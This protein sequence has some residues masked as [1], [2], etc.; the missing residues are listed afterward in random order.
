MSKNELAHISCEPGMARR[1]FLRKSALIALPVS[2]SGLAGPLMAAVAP[3]NYSLP[4]LRRGSTVVSV[5]SYGALGNGANDDTD[6]FQ[7]AINALPSSGGT[8]DV[9]AGTY[10]LDPTVS[11][12]LRSNM[13]LRLADGAQLAAK[14]NSKDRAYVLML[15]KVSNVEIS[16]GQIVGD[17]DN[18]LGTTGEWGHAIQVLGSTGV[19]IRD[20]HIS[21]CWGDGV[22]VGGAM[23][24]NSAPIPSRSVTIANIVSTGNRR[25][26]LTIANAHGVRVYDSEFSNCHGLSFGCGID[27]EPSNSNTAS[28]IRIENCLLDN[29]Q[30]NGIMVYK[31]VSTVTIKRCTI[32]S[33]AGYGILTIA[34][35]TGYISQNRIR[36][37]YLQGVMLRAGTYNY[38]VAG[39]YFRNNNTNLHGVRTTAGE[40]AT[41]SGLV[42]G[43]N[44]NGAHIQKTDDCRSISV[45]TNYYAK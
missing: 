25:H 36:H 11:V 20:I 24:A 8:V 7:R 45:T 31:R 10:V 38:Q 26:G 32:T 5:R 18:H 44:G 41:I 14:R 29:N 17:R 43:N 30:A 23:V 19:V 6:A 27:I 35:L 9:P 1:N 37:N 40:Y 4:T 42:A 15:F 13:H 34:P 16:G 2:L 22:C 39:N 12:R 21:K 3:A 28:D 33:N